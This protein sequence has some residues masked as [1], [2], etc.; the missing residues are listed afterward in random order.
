L[1]LLPALALHAVPSRPADVRHLNQTPP[2]TLHPRAT[3]AGT[4]A[5]KLIVR[6][7]RTSKA[8]GPSFIF[9]LLGFSFLGTDLATLER[10]RTNTIN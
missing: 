1:T 5:A 2:L 3:A 7:G 8:I 9:L 6:Q 4:S 10:T